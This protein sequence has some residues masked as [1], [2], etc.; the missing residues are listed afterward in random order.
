M[1]KQKN[2]LDNLAKQLEEAKAE[3]EQQRE[4]SFFKNTQLISQAQ[5]FESLMKEQMENENS[6]SAS[7]LHD[8]ANSSE[9]GSRITNQVYETEYHISI[10]EDK[11]SRA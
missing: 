11:I 5:M 1:D 8:D 4:T 7:K 10:I 6:W 3:L 2:Q 9:R